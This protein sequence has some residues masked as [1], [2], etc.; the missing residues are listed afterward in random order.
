[1]LFSLKALLFMASAVFFAQ[2]QS[3]TITSTLEAGYTA[4]G[5][6]VVATGATV[7]VSP[8]VT[9]MVTSMTTAAGGGGGGGGVG[10]SGT[11]SGTASN[12]QG[13]PANPARHEL[14]VLLSNF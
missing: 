11:T 2:A 10:G 5:A 1:M 12:H 4:T 13:G 14:V 9:T 6:T 8:V 3:T 7:T